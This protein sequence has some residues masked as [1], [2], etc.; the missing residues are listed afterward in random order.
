MENFPTIT[1][2]YGLDAYKL[3]LTHN[4]ATYFFCRSYILVF[5]RVYYAIH[6]NLY[7][8]LLPHIPYEF[9]NFSAS[10]TCL[11]VL[12]LEAMEAVYNDDHEPLPCC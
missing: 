11:A 2:W 3:L 10:D 12:V 1:V 5:K 8:T 6:T 7:T 4:Q 9:V